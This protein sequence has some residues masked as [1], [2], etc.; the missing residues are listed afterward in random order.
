MNTRSF[1]RWVPTAIVL[2]VFG[3]IFALGAVLD[4]WLATQAARGSIREAMVGDSRHVARWLLR[5]A[6]ENTLIAILCIFGW[7]LMRRRV[8]GALALGAI[9]VMAA[10]CIIL[11]QW[12]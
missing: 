2:W 3:V 10:V 6:I 9:A 11:H 7:Y 1:F 12:I 5:G 8:S 4:M